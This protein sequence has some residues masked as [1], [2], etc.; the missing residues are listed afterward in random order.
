EVASSLAIATVTDLLLRRF[1]MPQFSGEGLDPS[2]D[3]IGDWL[4]E[5]VQKANERIHAE[6]ANRGSDMGT[7]LVVA[8]ISGQT[9]Y[10]ANVGDSRAYI[11]PPATGEGQA[12][13][14]VTEDHSLVQRLQTM[15]QISAEEA[16]Y[17]PYRN[18]IYKSL[19]ERP[20][21][22]IDLFRE[23]V[24]AGSRLLLCSDGLSGMVSDPDLAAIL[25]ADADPHAACARMIA[26]ANA[27]GGM[28]NITAVTVYIDAQ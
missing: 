28:D 27:A 2:S 25:A 21:V 5:A 3:Q 11:L 15:G 19:G 22:E 23:A 20:Q 24:V 1:I 26:A 4:R 17:H 18:M 10:I 16:K 7:T 13:R 12:L 9:A 6:R 14:Q 8:L